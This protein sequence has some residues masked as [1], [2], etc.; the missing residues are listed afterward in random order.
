[1]PKLFMSLK[2]ID[3]KF[4]CDYCEGHLEGSHHY[5]DDQGNKYCNRHKGY[6]GRPK[7]VSKKKSKKNA[8]LPK[9][10]KGPKKIAALIK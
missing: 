9:P 10:K 5:T 7:I 1:M 4:V 2:E 8:Q 3:S 6:M